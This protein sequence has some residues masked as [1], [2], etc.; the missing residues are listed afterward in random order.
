MW[1]KRKYPNFKT[2]ELD[3]GHLFPLEEPVK[4]AEIIS[5]ILKQNT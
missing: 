4:T 5:E 1:W 2:I 3:G